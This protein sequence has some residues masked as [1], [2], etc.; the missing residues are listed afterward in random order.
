MKHEVI[1]LNNTASAGKYSGR[2]G[3]LHLL[4]DFYFALA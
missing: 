4:P 1:F 2:F 3:S